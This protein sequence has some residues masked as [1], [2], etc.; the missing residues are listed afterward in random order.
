MYSHC[1]EFIIY[2]KVGVLA[3]QL[4]LAAESLEDAKSVSN[5]QLFLMLDF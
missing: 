4:T 3:F 5:D 1:P 2:K